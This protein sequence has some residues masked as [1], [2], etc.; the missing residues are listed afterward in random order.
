M[1]P[2]QKSRAG[3]NRPCAPGRCGQRCE[4]EGSTDA[5]T[6][7][8]NRSARTRYLPRTEFQGR[9]RRLP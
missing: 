8:D 2:R 3:K 4:H 7:P 5:A 6:K 9:A 1:D